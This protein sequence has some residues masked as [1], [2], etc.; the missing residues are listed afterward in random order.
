[1]TRAHQR[2]SVEI[3]AVTGKK[4]HSRK[5]ALAHRDF[6]NNINVQAELRA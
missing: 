4:F 5:I 2:I 1:V 3:S 6:D